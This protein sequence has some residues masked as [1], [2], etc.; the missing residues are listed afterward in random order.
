MGCWN[1]VC[2]VSGYTV[3]MDDPVVAI[4][5]VGDRALPF[6][7]H[8][9]Y[10]DYGWYENIECDNEERMFT[11][12]RGHMV[13]REALNSVDGKIHSNDLDWETLEHWIHRR[14]LDLNLI[15]FAMREQGEHPVS[16]VCIHKSIW[17]GLLSTHIEPTILDARDRDAYNWVIMRD[18]LKKMYAG[19][20][21][22]LAE[23]ELLEDFPNEYSEIRKKLKYDMF[24]RRWFNAYEM[25]NS[26]T[27]FMLGAEALIQEITLLEHHSFD[28]AYHELEPV[29][30]W[31]WAMCVLNWA[32][33]R[34]TRPPHIGQSDTTRMA[35]HV[36]ALCIGAGA[37][38]DEFNAIPID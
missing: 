15:G 35:H 13:N 24:M 37:K 31:R 2:A 11:F 9:T 5:M 19:S 4:L 21:M 10:N 25:V 23:L 12:L 18:D 34:L 33:K 38:A 17:D 1:E 16:T 28:E 30:K 22:K 3:H 32:G 20:N 14:R 36:N 27:G 29:F 7:W 26:H 6:W 8:G